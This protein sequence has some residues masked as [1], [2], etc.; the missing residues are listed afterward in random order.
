MRGMS[1]RKARSS[2]YRAGLGF[3]VLFPPFLALGSYC[4]RA[5]FADEAGGALVLLA[6]VVSVLLFIALSYW[7]VK[8]VP[9]WLSWILGAVTWSVVLWMAH[10]TYEVA[11]TQGTE[12]FAS[13]PTHS[14]AAHE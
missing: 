7:W 10:I 4:G 12:P 13:S 3:F 8:L 9:E 1:M 14:P 11:I 5:Y 2:D 6:L